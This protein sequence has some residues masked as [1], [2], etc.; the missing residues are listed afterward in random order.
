MKDIAQ[1]EK[2]VLV[3]SIIKNG[4]FLNRCGK[5]GKNPTSETFQIPKFSMKRAS[6]STCPLIFHEPKTID[7]QKNVQLVLTEKMLNRAFFFTYIKG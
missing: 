4:L 1:H 6:I 2:N 5:I 7:E 3:K